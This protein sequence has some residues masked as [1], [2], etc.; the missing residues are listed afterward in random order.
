MDLDLLYEERN[1][2]TVFDMLSD[3]GGINSI[4][5]SVTFFLL[6]VINYNHLESYMAAQLFKLQPENIEQ[7]NDLQS[8]DTPK[9]GNIKEFLID[10]LPK[11]MICCKKTR[12]QIGLEQ[13]RASLDK[14]IDIIDMIKSRRFFYM[15]F[16]RLLS[17][18]EI[19]QL[20]E[21][22]LYKTIDPNRE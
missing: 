17:A 8:F 13:A 3:I 9:C 19:K 1:N 4:M 18:S 6:Q 11:R 22:S 14:E 15:A 7:K 12:R 5:F 21:R 10:S 16:Q 20:E 2:Y